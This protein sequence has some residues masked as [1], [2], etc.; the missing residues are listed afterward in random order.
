MRN[1]VLLF[2]VVVLAAHSNFCVGIAGT[3]QRHLSEKSVSTDTVAYTRLGKVNLNTIEISKD[4][5]LQ[6]AVCTLPPEVTLVYGGGIIRNGEL[7]GDNTKIKTNGRAFDRVRIKGTWNVPNISTAMFADLSYNNALRDVVALSNPDV[8]NKIVVEDGEYR[9]SVSEDAET[10][11]SLGSNTELVLNGDIILAPN[12][13][14]SYYIIQAK[15]DNI[16]INGKGSIVGDKHSHKG[17]D[18]E[19]GMGLFLRGANNSSVIGLTIR[20]C[21]GDCIY[22]GGNSKDVIIENCI[23]DHGRRQGISIVKADGVTIKD[24][25]ITNVAGTNPQY[26]ILL[27]PNPNCTVDHVVIDNV[28]VVDCIGGFASTKLNNEESRIIGDVQIRNCHVSVLKKNPLRMTGCESVTI[29]NSTIN[30]TN[31]RSAIYTNNSKHVIIRDNVINVT[32]RLYSSIRNTANEAIGKTGYKPIET[33]QSEREEVKNNEI[34][35]K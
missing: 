2:G 30:A 16:H 6:G 12:S 28:E 11:I 34:V 9:V 26:A 32:K 10:C 14:K 18:G 4:I 1:I 15:G 31:S 8:N 33:I 24:C 21:W 35:A 7:V 19:W 23:L 13:Y 25:K 29:E 17:K 27:E 22:I 20:D 3:V 5:D